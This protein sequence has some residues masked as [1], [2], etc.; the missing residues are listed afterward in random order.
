MNFQKSKSLSNYLE[1]LD[2]DI[3][4]VMEYLKILQKEE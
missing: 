1:L 4:E 3:N 2:L